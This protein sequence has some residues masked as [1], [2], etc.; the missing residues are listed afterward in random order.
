MAPITGNISTPEC[1]RN[2][3]GD[4]MKR[5]QYQQGCLY[6]EKRKAGPS[7]W[8]FRWRDGDS[9]R[10]VIVGSVEKFPTKA[11]AMKACELLRRN[12]NRETRTP[13]TVGELVE[14]YRLK[15]IS[16]SSTKS[17]S[18]KTA[19]ECYLRNQIVPVWGEYSLSDV[20][21]VAVEEWLRSLSLANGTKAKL[22]NLLHVIFT[23][24]MRH[25][26]LSHNPISL[27]RQST[28][29]ESIPDV[30]TV[31]EL[32]ALLAELKD[33][34]RTAVFVAAVTGLRA[35]ELFALKW[36]DFNF[37]DR[38]LRVNRAIVCQHVG[39]TKTEASGKP[40]PMSV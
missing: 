38:E 39:Q 18:T 7:V 30:L 4:S 20:R 12:V 32:V 24:A 27:V 37:D 25:E 22:R 10:K 6:K 15:E 35:S 14:H 17:F 34:W 13:R 40:I 1:V 36:E 21:P 5:T 9:H 31:E 11:T 2:Q 3:K 8:V 19:Y 23:H 28:K 29:R 26:W 16:N 33:P